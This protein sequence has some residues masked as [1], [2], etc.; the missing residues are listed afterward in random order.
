MSS[1][2]HFFR[3]LVWQ[4]CRQYEQME[5]T[6]PIRVHYADS[7]KKRDGGVI[8]RTL[9]ATNALDNVEYNYIS[10]YYYFVSNYHHSISLYHNNIL[11]YRSFSAWSINLI[12]FYPH[13]HQYKM[14]VYDQVD[15]NYNFL[16]TDRLIFLYYIV[17]CASYDC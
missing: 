9:N 13:C 15:R 7:E 11:I 3:R 12:S 14:Y 17:S 4:V 2:H 10:Y 8:H 1:R 16:T 5:M 6:R